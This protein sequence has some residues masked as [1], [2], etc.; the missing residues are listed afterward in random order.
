MLNPPGRA[1]SIRTGC[2]NADADPRRTAATILLA[3]IYRILRVHV[4]HRLAP[5]RSRTLSNQEVSR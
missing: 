4:R 1:L 2:S 3:E 5:F